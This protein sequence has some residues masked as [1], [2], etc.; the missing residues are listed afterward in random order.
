MDGERSPRKRI[1]LSEPNCRGRRTLALQPKGNLKDIEIIYINGLS[2]KFLELDSETEI[3]KPD[4]IYITE[5]K[6]D[7]SIHY[8]TL[9]LTQTIMFG[10]KIKQMEIER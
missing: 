8:V 1:L 9:G 10:E 3:Y 4:S 5:S 6:L 7:P 2:S